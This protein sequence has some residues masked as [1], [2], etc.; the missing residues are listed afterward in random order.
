MGRLKSNYSPLFVVEKKYSLE[1]LEKL[2]CS[3]GI[4]PEYARWGDIY[5]GLPYHHSSWNKLLESHIFSSFL[6][7]GCGSVCSVCI[8]YFF[9]SVSSPLWPNIVNSLV[10]IKTQS[11]LFW[12]YYRVGHC[13][14]FL[15]VC[16]ASPD[17]IVKISII[18][19]SLARY[20]AYDY[21]WVCFSCPS[22]SYAYLNVLLTVAD[23]LTRLVERIQHSSWEKIGKDTSAMT[24]LEGKIDYYW[25]VAISPLV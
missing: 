14:I 3:I 25:W 24:I 15:R 22:E 20:R 18:C 2:P 13:R 9:C 23:M 17:D 7:E 6:C 4:K 12:S 10:D 5:P 8:I 11:G 21:A 1:T 19:Y 16:N